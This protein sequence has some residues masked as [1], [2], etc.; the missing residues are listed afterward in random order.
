MYLLVFIENIFKN[1]IHSINYPTKRMYSTENPY[2]ICVY[3]S[4]RIYPLNKSL[5][6]IK[7][8]I[9]NEHS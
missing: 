9:L 1:L 4:D 7:F 8:L 5:K 3:N 6:N 2:V